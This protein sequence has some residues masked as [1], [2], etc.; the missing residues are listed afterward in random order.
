MDFQYSRPS[1]E[2][3]HQF[4]P[5]LSLTPSRPS[6]DEFVASPPETSNNQYPSCT[7]RQCDNT[8]PS[9]PT[10]SFQS[11]PTPPGRKTFGVHHAQHQ[12]QYGGIGNT[13]KP[14]K[15]DIGIREVHYGLTPAQFRRRVQNRS[16][17]QAF[18]NRKKQHVKDL[19]AK[20][21]DL[22][23]AQQQI[24]VEN[25]RLKQDLQRES[26]DNKI[27]RITSQIR[28]MSKSPIS[29][30]LATNL[31]RFN[32]SESSYNILQN[33]ANS[34]THR[35]INSNDGER[36]LAGSAAWD[37][38]INH[39]LFKKGLIDVSDVSERL[40]HYAYYNSQGPVFLQSFI[41]VA[42]EQSF[43]SKKNNLL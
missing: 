3:Y 17:Q 24:M 42:I 37:F 11:H 14:G 34:S 32:S 35:I 29:I 39:K 16:A 18:R 40:K 20:V 22:E 21:A 1:A 15:G 33:Q 2:P 12:Q 26:T 30:E 27:L 10:N 8:N 25:E 13:T 36:L 43:S 4:T 28:G 9:Q 23:A 19:E 5:I 7:Y 6:S 38:I 31:K 41:T